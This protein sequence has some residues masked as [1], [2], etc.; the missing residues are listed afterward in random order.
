MNESLQNFYLA[1]APW[2]PANWGVMSRLECV[3]KI[4]SLATELG[5][6]GEKTPVGLDHEL[7][8]IGDWLLM[9]A[10]AI[11][12]GESEFVAPQMLKVAN[13]LVGRANKQKSRKKDYAAN[14]LVTRLKRFAETGESI[15]L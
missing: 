3:K 1:A 9:L 5:D 10:L 4:C 2:I 6:E 11:S 14:E 7:C 15:L 12:L 13:R 8:R